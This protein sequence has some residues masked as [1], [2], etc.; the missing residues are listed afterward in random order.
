[1]WDSDQELDMRFEIYADKAREFRWRLI[2][3]NGRQIGASGEGYRTRASCLK[4]VE[5]IRAGAADA[6]I[7]DRSRTR[8]SAVTV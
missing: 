1:M 5:S 6:T 8:E 7:D 2:A 3:S 4:T